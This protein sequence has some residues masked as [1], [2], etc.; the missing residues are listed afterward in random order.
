MQ[1]SANTLMAH[2]AGLVF[3]NWLLRLVN[4]DAAPAKMT[5]PGK[6]NRGDT[7]FPK[8]A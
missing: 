2:F 5:N 1:A 8:P 3:T 7:V 4:Q 6:G